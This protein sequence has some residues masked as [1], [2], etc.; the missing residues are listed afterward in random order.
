MLNTYDHEK[1]GEESVFSEM[2]LPVVEVILT[3]LSFVC[4]VK[5]GE[6][7]K[8]TEAKHSKRAW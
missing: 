4:E 6:L 8:G 5:F 7:S 1:M 3:L 2:V